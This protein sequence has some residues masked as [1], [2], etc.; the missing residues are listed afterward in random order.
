[1]KFYIY[2]TLLAVLTLATTIM[3]LLDV[4][5]PWTVASGAVTLALVAL[6]FR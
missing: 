3:S 4:S 5:W 2:I 1:M 6:C